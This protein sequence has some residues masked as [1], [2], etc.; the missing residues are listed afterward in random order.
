M[1]YGITAMSFLALVLWPLGEFGQCYRVVF[2]L[3][4]VTLQPFPN[5]T[6]VRQSCIHNLFLGLSRSF[7]LA[8]KLLKP[9]SESKHTTIAGIYPAPCSES[10]AIGRTPGQLST[11]SRSARL[12]IVKAQAAAL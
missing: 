11:E 9:T 6:R 5:R 8:P 7:Q 4:M 3:L 1:D 12:M 10:I 2:A